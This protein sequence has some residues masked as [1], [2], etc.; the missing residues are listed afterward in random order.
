MLLHG[1]DLN[2]GDFINA[3]VQICQ[4]IEIWRVQWILKYDALKSSVRSVLPKMRVSFSFNIV[5]TLYCTSVLS[6][7]IIEYI[8]LEIA[9]VLVFVFPRKRFNGSRDEINMVLQHSS[10]FN[11]YFIIS[12]RFL[13]GT[14][15]ECYRHYKEVTIPGVFITTKIYAS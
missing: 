2:L 15:L 1:V 13:Y 4:F 5:S 6:W 14:C 12:R 8:I 3:F 7:Q 11:F 9:F 10:S